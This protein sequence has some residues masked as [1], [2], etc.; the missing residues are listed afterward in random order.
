MIKI[1]KNVPLPNPDGFQGKY[2][3]RKMEVG[4]S[5]FVVGKKT[6]SLTGCAYKLKELGMRFAFRTVTED[7]VKGVRAWRVE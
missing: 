5:F 7:G 4:D 3:W 1:D 6:N 2:P